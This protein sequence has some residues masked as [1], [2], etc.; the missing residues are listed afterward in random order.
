MQI[1]RKACAVGLHK[2][3]RGVT[4][5][6]LVE[7]S[8]SCNF[9]I[10]YFTYI[11]MHIAYTSSPRLSP[12]LCNHKLDYGVKILLSFKKITLNGSKSLMI[13]MCVT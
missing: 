9:L 5:K 8:K 2:F 3:S 13:N 11:D 12:D 6:L 1:R 10:T 4:I 7:D